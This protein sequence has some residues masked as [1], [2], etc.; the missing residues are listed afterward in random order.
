MRRRR[1]GMRMRRRRR[2]RRKRERAESRARKFHSC[3]M[4]LNSAVKQQGER[5]SPQTPHTREASTV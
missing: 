1:M 2:R 3:L 4:V 5:G